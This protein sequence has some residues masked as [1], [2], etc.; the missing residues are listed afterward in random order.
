MTFWDSLKK[1]FF[2]LAPMADVTDPAYRRLIAEY[3]KPDVT[4]T[5]FVSADGLYH[6]RTKGIM[7][8]EENPLVRDLQFGESERP[9]VAQL[10]GANPE[11]MAYAAKY[12][13]SLGYD[14][15][16][17]NMGCPDRSIEKQGAGAAMM[18]HPEDAPAIIAAARESGLPVSVKTRIGY[19]HESLDEWLPIL[20]KENLPALTVH[21]R[22]RKEMSLVAAHWELAE[23][24][25]HLRNT[26]AP[27]T[28]IIGNGDVRDLADATEKA[29][30]GGWDGIM[31]GR[32]IFGNPW[33]FTGKELSD[34]S[35][36]DRLAALLQ[37]AE[38]FDEL[39]PKK[40]FHILK[41][42]FKAFVNGWPGAAELRG[43]LMEAEDI[44]Q[45]RTIITRL[46]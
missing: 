2:V 1:P 15:I 43:E 7:T 30:A 34:I 36:E 32:A 44:G 25:V 11:T 10:F 20:L 17:I 28:R 33:V 5:E 26:Y 42:H 22:T 18:K 4:W 23:R 31:L 9:I 6:T 40:S 37:L 29:D 46:V 35:R 41:K 16:D 12:A 24:V 19:N 13:A 14:G 39:R 45:L 38:Y 27:N 21:L 8:D 3:G